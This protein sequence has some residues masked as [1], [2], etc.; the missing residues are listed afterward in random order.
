MATLTLKNIPE[1]L[2]RRLKKRA[3]LH[4]RSLNSEVLACLEDAVQSKS[5]DPNDLLQVARR[6]RQEVTFRLTPRKLSE[7]KNIGRP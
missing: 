2:R 1:T 3:Q 4:R 7:F 5:L 6:L